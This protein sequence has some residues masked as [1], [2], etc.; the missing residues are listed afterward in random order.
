MN[1]AVTAIIALVVT[2]LVFAGMWAGW[3][4]RG[5]AGKDYATDLTP[6]TGDRLEYF[7][8]VT[9]VSTTP[10]NEPLVRLSVP[11]LVYKGD[12]SI[13]VRSDGVTI[14]VTGEEPVHLSTD[15]LLGHHSARA[16]VGKAVERDGLEVLE[17]SASDTHVGSGFRFHTPEEQLRFA[18][19]IDL[20]TKNAPGAMPDATTP[21]NT[22]Q[23][24]A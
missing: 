10:V 14:Q 4:A 5:R 15:R 12:A 23:E 22:L 11:G 20:M 9:Y 3:A 17:W 16:R 1:L 8:A 6:P 7:P 19:A 18:R 13:D 2:A 24:E 21:T